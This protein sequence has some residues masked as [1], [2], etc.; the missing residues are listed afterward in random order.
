[1]SPNIPKKRGRPN[2]D[3]SKRQRDVS[4]ALLKVI[5]EQGFENASMRAIALEA[6]LHDRVLSH[7]FTGKEELIFHAV[8]L[9]I[10]SS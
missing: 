6:R 8:Q 7:Y 5:G 10:R 3:R 2:G 4:D 9:V 1:M